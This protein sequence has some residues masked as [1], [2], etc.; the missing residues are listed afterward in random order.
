MKISALLTVFDAVITI[1][2]TVTVNPRADTRVAPILV[3][4]TVVVNNAG[5]IAPRASLKRFF[6]L[7]VSPV[8]S[9]A[10][11][12]CTEASRELRRRS[13]IVGL[14]QVVNGG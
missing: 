8:G 3:V 4:L 6:A 7:V 2:T 10:W 13:P 11:V 9:D 1:I 14:M 12:I 5:I